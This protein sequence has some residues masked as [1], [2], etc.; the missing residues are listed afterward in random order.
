MG[1]ARYR[2]ACALNGAFI[3]VCGGVSLLTCE[4]YD[5]GLSNP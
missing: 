1:T 4:R 2:H 3:Y 5:I